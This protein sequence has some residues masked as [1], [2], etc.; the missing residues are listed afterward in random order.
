[1]KTLGQQLEQSGGQGQAGPLIVEDYD[2]TTL[3]PPGWR[4]ALDGDGSIL[5]EGTPEG[6]P[7]GAE[8]SPEEGEW[9]GR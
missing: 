6:T 2:A 4:A 1:M 3:V 7:E 5:L 9:E 8:R